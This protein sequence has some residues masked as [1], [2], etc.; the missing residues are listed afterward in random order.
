[1]RPAGPSHGSARQALE[2]L[3]LGRLGV[4]QY[5]L[6]APNPTDCARLE[7]RSREAGQRRLECRVERLQDHA[8]AAPPQDLHDLVRAQA[9]E[10]PRVRRGAQERQCRDAGRSGPGRVQSDLGLHFK[11]LDR[12]QQGR[13]R[14]LGEF[15]GVLGPGRLTRRH[16]VERALATRAILE[17]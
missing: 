11:A 6:G 8:H 14:P 4:D 17:V 3:G 13:A 5:V 12:L 7:T 1:M 10:V 15:A 16:S 2:Q 9:A